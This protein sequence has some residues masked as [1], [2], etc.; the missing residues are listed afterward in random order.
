[1]TRRRTLHLTALLVAAAMLMACTAALL[2]AMP[3]KAEAIFSGKNGRIAYSVLGGGMDKAIYT[4]NPGGGGKT[5]VTRGYHPSY[6]PT[7]RRSPT[8]GTKA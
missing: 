2:V 3:E 1:M 5:R 6:S 4:I 7:A 8:R